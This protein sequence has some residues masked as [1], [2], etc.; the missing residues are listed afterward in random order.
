MRTFPSLLS[1]RIFVF[2]LHLIQSSVMSSS[3]TNT[4]T[5][6]TTIAAAA[7][8]A[9]AAT[10]FDS[11]FLMSPLHE[12]SGKCA[13]EAMLPQLYGLDCDTT[14]EGA[15]TPE[16]QMRPLAAHN[17]RA[18][19]PQY[20]SVMARFRVHCVRYV[21][22]A[23]VMIIMAASKVLQQTQTQTT[24][25][26]RTHNDVRLHQK[27][28]LLG[29][30]RAIRAMVVLLKVLICSAAVVIMITQQPYSADSSLSETILNRLGWSNYFDATAATTAAISMGK[31][32]GA[33][34]TATTATTATTFT[35]TTTTTTTATTA[36]TIWPIWSDSIFAIITYMWSIVA[37][38]PTIMATDGGGSDL[39][40]V[41][42]STQS[43]VDLTNYRHHHQAAIADEVSRHLFLALPELESRL[44]REMT[45]T[46]WLMSAGDKTGHADYALAAAGAKVVFAATARSESGSGS[47]SGSGLGGAPSQPL[48]LP[49]QGDQGPE[50]MLNSDMTPGRCWAFAGSSASAMIR[51]C[52]PT[53]ITAIGLEHLPPALA[54]RG[55]V[56]SAPRHVR[57]YAMMF[58]KQQQPRRKKGEDENN[59][60]SMTVTEAA[61]A[62]AI[63]ACLSDENDNNSLGGGDGGGGGGGKENR[64]GASTS[65]AT[66]NDFGH[67]GT[68]TTT[69]TTTTTTTNF[70]SCDH[71]VIWQVASFQFR[72]D[73]SPMALQTVRA[74]AP[75]PR[76]LDNNN[77]NVV[78]AATHIWL[79]IDGNH[80]HPEFTCVYRL[81]VH[82]DAVDF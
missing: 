26:T 67:D 1:P 8:A 10:T 23:G 22:F 12:K 16:M 62:M 32:I 29:S 2:V 51:L 54:P 64:N 30:M 38:C 28:R 50:A 36:T 20:S 33:L 18:S 25:T 45:E 75:P 57:I 52:Q 49:A 39:D 81:R 44:R 37:V 42:S 56:A 11:S 72:P 9:A 4:T 31:E 60:Q 40:T 34:T 69:T 21:A 78:T 68:A 13:A 80:G 73:T 82:G 17:P 7:A 66:F 24:R 61:M 5:T 55:D 63:Q 15:W 74:A 35:T 41:P 53:I 58:M 70:L 48:N 46:V 59:D 77:N 76:Y 43:A 71:I 3:S 65:D 14:E 6:T 27:S 19:P 79:S 47:G